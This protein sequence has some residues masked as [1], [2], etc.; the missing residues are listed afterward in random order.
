MNREVWLNIIRFILLFLFQVLILNNI[1]LSGYINPYLYVLFI[2]MLP[3]QTPRWLLLSAAF[4]MGLAI[5]MFTNT[6][7]LHAAAST[8]MAFCRPSLIS[9]LSSN[10]EIEPGSSPDIHVFGFAWFLAYSSILVLLHHLVL[11][12]LEVFRFSDFFITMSRVLIS[13]A[14]TIV[15]ILLTQLLFYGHKK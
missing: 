1:Q 10:K 4:F 12:Y 9:L 11:F 6:P 7:G 3:F 5:D 15:L 14:I 2:L 13:S 8:F